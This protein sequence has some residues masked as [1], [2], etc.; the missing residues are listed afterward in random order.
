MV[1]KKKVSL[2]RHQFRL[3]VRI[4]RTTLFWF[5]PLPLPPSVA[6][7]DCKKNWQRARSNS[8][9]SGPSLTHSLPSLAKKKVIKGGVF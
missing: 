3:G 8:M 7:K 9:W 5:S 1:A 4:Y 2:R 6:D